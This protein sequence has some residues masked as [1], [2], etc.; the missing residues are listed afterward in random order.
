MIKLKAFADDKLSIAK[1]TIS[2]LEKV[3]NTLGKGENP[4]YCMSADQVSV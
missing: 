2:L 3:E 4:G 1:M